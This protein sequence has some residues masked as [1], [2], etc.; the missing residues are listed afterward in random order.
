MLCDKPE[1]VIAMRG[2]LN[3]HL[4]SVWTSRWWTEFLMAVIVDGSS[5]GCVTVIRNFCWLFEGHQNFCV[6]VIR[7]LVGCVTVDTFSVGCVTQNFCWL[8]EPGKHLESGEFWN[9]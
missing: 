5:V 1:A 9:V 7:L 8:W 6:R 3:M 2:S 4:L